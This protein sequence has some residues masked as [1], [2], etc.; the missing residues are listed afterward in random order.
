MKLQQVVILIIIL[1]LFGQRILLN[2]K[3]KFD[4]LVE[5]LEKRKGL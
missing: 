4:A 3:K 2:Q 5:S 1:F